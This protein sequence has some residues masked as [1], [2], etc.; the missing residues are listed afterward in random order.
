VCRDGVWCVEFDRPIQVSLPDADQ[1]DLILH[2][3]RL[4]EVNDAA[5]ALTGLDDPREQPLL[6]LI[7][8]EAGLA[9]AVREFVSSNYQLPDRDVRVDR[10]G[11]FTP[12]KIALTGVVEDGQLARIW[13]VLRPSLE[14]RTV[15]E[16]LRH[17]QRMAMVG[18]VAGSVAHDFNNLLTAIMG[19]GELVRDT[20]GD[21][22]V[23]AP[24]IE[25]VLNAG[26]RAEMLTRQLL[27]FCRR[28]RDKAEVFDLSVVVH[29][30][31]P[32]IRRLAG[33][34][35]DLDIRFDAEPAL[36]SAD[37]SQIELVVLNIAANA[38]EAMPTGGR[39]TI[40]TTSAQRED[41]LGV[42][43]T[44]GD[45][46]QGI[47]EEVRGRIFEPFFTTKPN[48]TGLGLAMAH[49]IVA[50]C[51]GRIEVQSVCGQGATFVIALARI[52]E[53]AFPSDDVTILD[54][55]RCG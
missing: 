29:E 40:T 27:S 24:D 10:H 19:Y 32:L 1:V 31:E 38:R 5:R 15:A 52:A 12:L 13:G 28:Q 33:N 47:D 4:T 35:V 34:S 43:L 6:A 51:G 9:P 8:D 36:V 49:D 39:L 7:N 54:R 26:K 18:R 16:Q 14:P 17:T 50:Q 3:G 21:E 30:L 48:G 23:C 37:R 25:Q 44:I 55:L 46:G 45:T 22:H 2:S 53:R 20:I 42:L 41:G 11:S